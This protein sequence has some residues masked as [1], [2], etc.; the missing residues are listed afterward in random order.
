MHSKRVKTYLFECTKRGEKGD[1]LCRRCPVCRSGWT[2]HQSRKLQSK[3]GNCNSRMTGRETRGG[4]GGICMGAQTQW[5]PW[6]HNKLG[7]VPWLSAASVCEMAL[8]LRALLEEPFSDSF[9]PLQVPCRAFSSYLIPFSSYLILCN[10]RDS[11]QCVVICWSRCVSSIGGHC[12][13]KPSM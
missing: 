8:S 1:P 7:W 12:V 11:A 13:Q 9:H 2:Q 5:V 10:L 6:G 4:V 3:K